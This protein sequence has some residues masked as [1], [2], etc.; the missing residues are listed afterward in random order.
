[1]TEFPDVPNL[2]GVPPVPRDSNATTSTSSGSETIVVRSSRRRWGLYRDGGSQAVIAD[3]VISV[4]ISKEHTI[5]NYPIEGG[6]FESYNKVEKPYEGRVV[7]TKGGSMDEKKQFITRL[8][9][10]QQNLTTYNVVT[11]ERTYKN[12]NIIKVSI[13]RTRDQGADMIRAEISVAEVRKTANREFSH[14]EPL[15]DAGA[16][17]SIDS[18]YDPTGGPL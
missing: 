16:V 13:E 6:A 8:E 10:M 4:A 7:M 18:G 1:M 3:S 17:Q 14:V 5:A 12:A 2:E 11:P 9:S 15:Y